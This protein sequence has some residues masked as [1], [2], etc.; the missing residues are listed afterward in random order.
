[1]GPSGEVATMYKC[2]N[3][4]EIFDE[5]HEYYETHG[6]KDGMYEHMSCCPYC[7]G[8]YDEVDSE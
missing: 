8:D 3:C 5:P 7:G 2:N 4:G 6:F 1:M